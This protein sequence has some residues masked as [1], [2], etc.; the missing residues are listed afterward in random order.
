[1]SAALRNWAGN[2][3]FTSTI[4]R[5]PTQVAELQALVAA[6]RRIHALGS[7]H[8]FNR[9]ADTSGEFVSVRRLELPIEIDEAARTAIV[10]GGAR[11]AEVTAALDARGWAL[12]NLGSLPHIA[13]AGA[14]ATGTHGAGTTNQ[15][16][17]AAVESVEFVRGDG[18][19]VTLRR[20]DDAFLGAVVAL[21]ALGI[22]TRAALRIEP[23]YT[24]RQDVYLDMPFATA[25]EH[26]LEILDAAYSVSLFSTWQRPD[27]VNAVWRKSKAIR[28]DAAAE[29]EWL[30]A[31]LATTPQN[32]IPGLD[33]TGTSPQLGQ[34]GPWHERLPHF[35]PDYV[36]SSGEELQ[37]EYFLPREAA[38]QVLHALRSVAAELAPPLQVFELRTIAADE[39]WLSPCHGRATVAA[40]FTWI[41]DLDAVRPALRAVEAALEPLDARPHWGKVFLAADAARFDAI[42]PRLNDFRKLAAAYDPERCFGNDFLDRYV[43]R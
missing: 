2:V 21:G 15:N 17:A 18:E 8:S 11:F 31:R 29:T 32:P 24:M 41:G 9:I 33:P 20:L 12:H 7:G 19:L 34:V 5:E 27:I 39:L 37:S 28:T 35:H 36:P 14:C 26:T 30:G 43:Y 25:A 10:P 16:L 23:A 22:V 3:E 6:S 1:M 4:L 40:H 38:P 13:V 42:Y